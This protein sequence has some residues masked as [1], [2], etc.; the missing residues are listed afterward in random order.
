MLKLILLCFALLCTLSRSEC[1][2]SQGCQSVPFFPLWCEAAGRK[3]PA[4]WSPV[5]TGTCWTRLGFCWTSGREKLPHH[6][7]HACVPWPAFLGLCSGYSPSLPALLLDINIKVCQNPILA[8]CKVIW[9]PNTESTM[10]KQDISQNILLLVKFC[11]HCM[12]KA[13]WRKVKRF[14]FL[15]V[16]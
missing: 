12:L 6:Q 2:I 9:E 16:I 7:L 4:R 15:C 1:N 10:E 3:G 14:C 11:T 8:F 5:S 13:C